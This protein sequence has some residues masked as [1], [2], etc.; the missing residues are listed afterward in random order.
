MKD[1]GILNPE[2]D[3]IDLAQGAKPKRRRSRPSLK[4]KKDDVRQKRKE[5]DM[6]KDYKQ[7]KQDLDALIRA[8]DRLSN[9]SVSLSGNSRLQKKI[10]PIL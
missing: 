7:M 6:A 3:A 8:N 10:R 2:D 5:Y 4:K 1:D 9:T